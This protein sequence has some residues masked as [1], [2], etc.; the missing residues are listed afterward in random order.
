MGTLSLLF[1]VSCFSDKGNSPTPTAS[2]YFPQG[3]AGLE[4]AR[5]PTEVTLKD[6]DTLR[7]TAAPVKKTLMGREVRMLAYNGSIPG[8]LIR[9]QE[10]AQITLI[11]KNKIGIPTILHS[12]GLRL[13]SRYDG[14]ADV[15]KPIA[16]GDSFSY[17][18]KFP[19]PGLFWYHPHFREDYAKELGLYGN[20]MVI[21]KDTNYWY[22]VN[23]EMLPRSGPTRWIAP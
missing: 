13:D 21:P 7:M 20:F 23:R 12:H 1:L 11:L 6:G 19:D 10:G 4:T 2:K 15:Q 18:L 14:T 16:D 17:T 5:A 22:P 8:P 3:V 9:V